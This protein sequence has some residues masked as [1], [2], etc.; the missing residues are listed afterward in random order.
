[1]PY[2]RLPNTDIARMRA[3][4]S[5]MNQFDIDDNAGNAAFSFSLK[6]KIDIFAPHYKSAITNSKNAKKQQGSNSH[7]FAELT[8]KARIYLSHFIQVINMCIIRGELK[9]S[10]RTFY[11]IEEDDVKIPQLITEQDLL[12]WGKK[13]I[14]G[15]QERIHQR[16]GN[17]IYCPTIAMVRVNYENFRQAYEFQKQLQVNSARFSAEVAR[18][19]EEADKLILA[20]WNEVEDFYTKKENNP[21]TR[22]EKCETYGLIYVFRKKELERIK[23]SENELRLF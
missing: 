3:L 17:P 13:I 10:A 9:P 20:I 5:A 15:E 23:I 2:R 8:K 16:M 12:T 18:Y 4:S 19:R 21:L 7:D 1:M 6:Q 14:E 22:R 11:G